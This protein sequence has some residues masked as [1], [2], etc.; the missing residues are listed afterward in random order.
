MRQLPRLF[1]LLL[2]SLFVI[3]ISCE[4]SAGPAATSE[5]AEPEPVEEAAPQ[6]EDSSGR[7]VE[8]DAVEETPTPA[9]ETPAD[10]AAVIVFIMGE[11][12]IQEAGG[13][14][15][16]DVGTALSADDV[17]QVADDSYCEIE[18]G[19][20]ATVRVDADSEVTLRRL[21]F[22][23]EESDARLALNRGAVL[24]RVRT[25]AQGSA[26]AVQ[27]ESSVAGVRGTEFSARVDESG[28]VKIAVR[29]GRVGVRPLVPEIDD[30]DPVDDVQR[31]T[32]RRIQEALDQ[33]SVGVSDSQEIEVTRERAAEAANALVSVRGN[34]GEVL[35]TANEEGAEEIAESAREAAP[36][37]TATLPEVRP[38]SEESR[39]ALDQILQLHAVSVFQQ[40]EE[41]EQREQ[42]EDRADRAEEAEPQLVSLEV[43]AEPGDAK[44]ILNDDRRAVGRF[45]GVFPRGEEL[46]VR[47]EAEGYQPVS[48]PIILRDVQGRSL[49]VTLD[50]V[51][52]TSLRVRTD[53]VEAEIVID[54]EIVGTGTFERTYPLGTDLSVTA[55]H[56]DYTAETRDIVI[57]EEGTRDFTIAMTERPP[58]REREESESAAGEG[59]GAPEQQVPE[60][61]ETAEVTVV[62]EPSNAR[63]TLNGRNYDGARATESFEV[64]TQ[65]TM[66]VSAPGY[67]SQSRRILV[68]SSG[69]RHTLNLEREIVTRRIFVEA[70]PRSAQILLNGRDVGTGSYRG[71]HEVGTRL[72]FSAQA[73]E[74]YPDTLVV[75]V[76]ENLPSRYRI[77]LERRPVERSIT[78]TPNPADAT[79][80]MAGAAPRQ[81]GN[82]YPLTAGNEYEVVIE[83][84]GFATL[85]QTIAVSD[86]SPEE[87]TFDLEPQPLLWERTVVGAGIIRALREAGG[88]LYWAAADG[89]LGAVDDTGRPRWQVQSRNAPNENSMP[90]IAGNRVYFSGSAEFLRIN[91]DTGSVIERQDL[92][93]DRAHVFGRTVTPLPSGYAYPTNESVEIVDDE[94]SARSVAIP[95][96]STMSAV[97]HDGTLYLA[98][99][100]GTMI[101]VDVAAGEVVREIS[102]DAVQPVAHAP[103][104]WNDTAYFSGRR[105]TFVA[106]SLGAGRTSWTYDLGE[107]VFHCPTASS[108]GVYVHAGETLFALGHDGSEL[109]A[110][111]SDAAGPAAVA[112]GEVAYPTTDGALRILHARSGAEVARYDLPEVARAR[113]VYRGNRIFVATTGGRVVA[114]HREGLGR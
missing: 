111:Q 40:R 38:L 25:L 86:D 113:P 51:P 10:I 35:R 42:R 69:N 68:Q 90:V 107:G 2:L 34:V 22:S 100:R 43:V 53:P 23:E 11:A 99:N 103:V 73:E 29:E 62:A 74:Y 60:E 55:V 46:S 76:S 19:N 79:V 97:L 96:G 4:P 18:L 110:P 26:Y 41:R 5:E 106:V 65:V 17:I 72:R 30:F 83:R 91:A 21:L 50:P 89:T 28:A 20:V 85:R 9:V 27:T 56:P 109:F 33:A 93:G 112:N 7:L 44:I 98:D 64:G 48:F 36:R 31:R 84:P 8:S 102:T 16:L 15:P 14:S 94:G 95:E 57:E 70:T 52:E 12:L 71:E 3:L 49:T 77:E 81:G 47:V 82:A 63:I 61:P 58:E 67:V 45:A 105:G 78:I 104:I 101:G 66:E 54:G 32:V 39:V 1:L 92:S 80:R 24:S 75:R 87:Y 88:V 108:E 59:A 13:W 37:A 114:L 6:A